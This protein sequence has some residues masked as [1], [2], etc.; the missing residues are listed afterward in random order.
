VRYLA[1]VTLPGGAEAVL[2]A[3]YPG[4]P[5]VRDE[6]MVLSLYGG[7]GIVAPIA[8]EPARGLLLLP[9][10]RPGT[11]LSL[12]ALAD[13]AAATTVAASLMRFDRPPPAGLSL[14]LTT[15]WTAAIGRALE[16]LDRGGGPAP[17]VA[18]PRE[19][20]TM[21]AR[22]ADALHATA[23]PPVVLHGDLQHFN[24][25]RS[26]GGWSVIDP[27]GVIGER[28]FEAGPLLRNP[29]GN[30]PHGAALEALLATRV[31]IVAGELRASRQRIAAWGAVNAVTSAC[32][33]LE[34][35]GSPRDALEVAEALLRAFPA[36]AELQGES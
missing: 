27:K 21:A 28:E 2:K 31:A 25:L 23:G 9:R 7:R 36:T 33:S 15:D 16:G 20:L 26:G 29:A 14:P 11:D 6:R 18:V 24:I 35:G 19:L 8:V 13:D 17:A 3:G 34:S 32:W 30:L 12:V 4:D 5:E 1:Y 10:I 22:V